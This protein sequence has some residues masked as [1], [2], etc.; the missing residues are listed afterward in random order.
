MDAQGEGRKGGEVL[1]EEGH[2][3]ER[4]E[5][6]EEVEGKD[7]GGGASSVAWGI[8]L[9]ERRG[10]GGGAEK[11]RRADKCQ[12]TAYDDALW[13]DLRPES[14]Q[15]RMLTIKD[16]FFDPMK[17]LMSCKWRCSHRVR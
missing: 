2:A 12:C 15:R 6:D 7:G 10:G 8:E 11:K 13:S 4:L 16:N 3:A 9:R 17:E 1:T 5:E 14:E